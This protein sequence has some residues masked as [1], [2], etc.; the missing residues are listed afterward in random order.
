MIKLGPISEIDYARLRS[1][2][3]D[4]AVYKWC[5]QYEPLEAWTHGSWLESL[6][7]RTDVKMYGIYESGEFI[8][9]PIGVCGFTS[10]DLINRHAE[11]SIY[12]DP[13]L[14]G[15]GRGQLA[16]RALV[17]H[18]FKALG[19]HHIYGETFDGNPAARSFEKVGFTK[20][21]TRRQFYYREGKFI[22]AHL[23]SILRDEWKL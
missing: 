6:K 12:L 10:L 16:L 3:N 15:K 20:E 21:G 11:F 1:W 7:T 17:D 8:N 19:L 18:G 2:R 22:D 13:E 23:Y 4:P 9:G 14:T 5:R